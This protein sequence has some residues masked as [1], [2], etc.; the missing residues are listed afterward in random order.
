[1]LLCGALLSMAQL[2]PVRESFATGNNKQLFNE[3]LPPHKMS[4]GLYTI[5]LYVCALTTLSILVGLYTKRSSSLFGFW[6]SVSAISVALGQLPPQLHEG[7]LGRIP[8]YGSFPNPA[9]QLY[10]SAFAAAVLC[11]FA[12]TGLS[13]VSLKTNSP[14][15]PSR[16]VVASAG[17]LIILA[18]VLSMSLMALNGAPASYIDS[19]LIAPDFVKFIMSR[20]T[21]VEGGR[22]INLTGAGDDA[23][24]ATLRVPVVSPAHELRIIN[25]PGQ[26]SPPGLS[27]I[28]GDLRTDGTIGDRNL[29]M[30]Y[31]QGLNLLNV[32]YLLLADKKPS[33]GDQFPDLLSVD[34]IKFS[35]DKLGI[36]MREGNRINIITEAGIIASEI[37]LISSMGFS[38][39][40]A[41]DAVVCVV[42]L[43]TKKDGILAREIRAGKDTA[44]WSYDKPE[45][46]RVIKH[47]KARVAV[48]GPAGD[49]AGHEYIATLKFDRAEI[50]KIEFEYV[51]PRSRLGVHQVSLHDSETETSV[52]ITPRDLIND[53]WR[54]VGQFEHVGVY[55]NR[56]MTSRAWFVGRTV[57]VTE[58][59]MPE[60]IK[61]GVLPDGTPFDPR[62]TVLINRMEF[63]RNDAK[64]PIIGSRD[65]A[66]VT[67][68]SS[69][70]NRIELTT[71][72]INQGFLVLSEPYFRGWDA[73]VDGRRTPV[74]RVNYLLQGIPVGAGRHRVE[75]KY[76]PP[77]ARNGASYTLLGVLILIAG[78]FVGRQS[79]GR[80]YSFVTSICPPAHFGGSAAT[81]VRSLRAYLESLRKKLSAGPVVSGLFALISGAG[82]VYYSYLMIRYANKVVTGN[83]S[84][85]YASLAKYMTQLRVIQPVV[86]LSQFDLPLEFTD[87]FIPITYLSSEAQP[88]VMV[89]QYPPGHPMLISAFSLLLGWEVGPFI[90]GPMSAIVSSILT[91]LIARE[92]GLSRRLSTAAGFMLALSPIVVYMGVQMVSDVPSMMLDL[93]AVY[94]SLVCRRKIKWAWVAGLSLGLAVLV[95]PTNMF[96]IIPLVFCLP[97]SIRGAVYFALGGLPAAFFLCVYNISVYGGLFQYYAS[98]GSGTFDMF[99]LSFSFMYARFQYYTYWI[100]R[101]MSP[102]ILFGWLGVIF[103]HE[104]SLRNR[105]MLI[106]WFGSFI[107]VYC[108]YSW[109]GDWWF[110]RFLLPGWPALIIGSLI[111]AKYIGDMLG[112]HLGVNG[113]LL[114]SRAPSL[115]LITLV[116]ACSIYSIKSFGMFDAYLGA[117]R[118]KDVVMWANGQMP[119]DAIVVADYWGGMLKYYGGRSIVLYSRMNEAKWKTLK[120]KVRSKGVSIYALLAQTSVESA[121]K[122]MPGKWSL[123]GTYEHQ[124]LW[125]VST[126]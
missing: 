18:P 75:F 81:R 9:S 125:K 94:A 109:Y 83:D 99:S 124:T 103:N 36:T 112:R 49:F 70:T 21:E 14:S 41:D 59:E 56:A 72:N 39:Q 84:Y 43:H 12:F 115:V 66:V 104:L 68:D 44:E 6:T 121:R 40:V 65:G 17:G 101:L 34:G 73:F 19:R 46:L 97:L 86:E 110:T 51:D 119:P 57:A 74:N 7:V 67:V 20:E 8:I 55:E 48:S 37:A 29:L 16:W 80:V 113:S 118:E 92:I 117:Q 30:S 123:L 60:I 25:S 26:I 13:K 33:S 38:E 126:E 42:R 52:P 3:L 63:A 53:K 116:I 28:A 85:G 71:Q 107:A 87:V 61:S 111:T 11:G 15:I 69:E 5:I 106:S 89:S 105:A 58:S 122:N 32:K 82:I 96:M 45:I 35:R 22:A 88:G 23:S 50:N 47:K 93:I 114:A 54:K 24:D 64:L 31:H 108:S 4:S 100:A 27:A 102:L 90:V 10:F 91:Y 79:P 98:Y 77:A 95:R 62:E 1:M 76:Q 120:E 2:L 78:L